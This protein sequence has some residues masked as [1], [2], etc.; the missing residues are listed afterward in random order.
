MCVCVWGGGGGTAT[1][2]FYNWC[3]I[4]KFPSFQGGG[5]EQSL[6]EKLRKVKQHNTTCLKESFFKEKLGASGGTQNQAHHHAHVRS[7]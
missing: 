1:A 4:T 7:L 2:S 3:Q 6:Q 5:H